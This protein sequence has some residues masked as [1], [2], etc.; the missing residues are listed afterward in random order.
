[1][2]DFTYKNLEKALSSNS[3]PV[4]RQG[5]YYAMRNGSAFWQISPVDFDESKVNG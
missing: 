3:L 2:S 5:N 4:V 1:M